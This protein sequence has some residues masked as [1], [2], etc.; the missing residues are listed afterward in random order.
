MSGVNVA[1]GL[2]AS[3]RRINTFLL[4][5]GR[6]K[7]VGP[8]ALRKLLSERA[9]EISSTEVLDEAF[10]RSLGIM[11]ISKALGGVDAPEVWA[12]Y[13]SEAD[14]VVERAIANDISILN[15]L[16][17]E[18]PRRPLLNAKYPPI[19]FCGGDVSALNGEKSVAIVGTREPTDYGSRAGAKLAEVMAADGYVVVSGLAIGSDTLAHEGA[20]EGGGKTVAVLPTPI[21]APVYPRQNQALA[22]RI[23]ATGGA[24][25]SEYEPGAQMHDKQLVS[26]LVARDEWQPAL[27]DGLVAIETSVSGGTNHAVRHALDTHTPVAVFDLSGIQ[28]VD[29]FAD[30]RF[31]GN[32][33]YLEKGASPITLKG[34]DGVGELRMDSRTIREFEARMAAYRDGY[35]NGGG[36]ALSGADDGQLSLGL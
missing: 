18:Y 29:F 35:L 25:V 3:S 17:A 9:G 11:A 32:V 1:V 15:P 19:L 23:V 36:G 6:L 27:A 16:M 24:L 34:G 12:F 26:N 31:G 7:G 13:E 4:T 20:L 22:D 2:D 10:A 33:N 5:L 8:A 28:G 30:E 14:A 21:D